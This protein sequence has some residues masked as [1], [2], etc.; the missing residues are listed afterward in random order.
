MTEKSGATIYVAK[1]QERLEAC[2]SHT[3]DQ[4]DILILSYLIVEKQNFDLVE[5]Y[6]VI[7]LKS[8]TSTLKNSFVVIIPSLRPDEAADFAYE[9]ALSWEEGSL[10]A[11]LANLSTK[12][13]SN[14]TADRDSAP[15]S[16]T[17]EYTITLDPI[18]KMLRS[19]SW[20]GK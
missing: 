16:T 11:F 5:R 20:L 7:F 12:L 8:I 10:Q 19:K 18:Y 14:P 13:A 4:L 9:I 1:Y 17:T 2:L 3:D 6:A 15:T